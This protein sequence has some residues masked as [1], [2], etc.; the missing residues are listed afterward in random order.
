MFQIFNAL[1]IQT[2]ISYYIIFTPIWRGFDSPSSIHLA[3]FN[4]TREWKQFWLTQQYTLRSLQ[5]DPAVYTPLP[6]TRPSSIQYTPCSL[7]H[8]P[9]VYTPLP[10]TR[11]ENGWRNEGYNILTLQNIK[12]EKIKSEPATQETHLRSLSAGSP[13]RV[14]SYHTGSISW[15]LEPR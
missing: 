11:Q 7:Q 1:V 14:G 9:A 12:F 4:A 15:F 5:H 8:D 6:S 2:H 13:P 3:P 10:S